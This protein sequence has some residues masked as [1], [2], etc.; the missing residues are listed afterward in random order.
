MIEFSEN[1]ANAMM[2]KNRDIIPS[3]IH[4]P[5]RIRDARGRQP[6]DGKTPSTRFVSTD[7]IGLRMAPALA[8]AIDAWRS[9][10]PKAISRSEAIR[11]LLKF[12]LA[13]APL[14]TT[15]ADDQ[16]F[17]ERRRQ[18]VR[19]LLPYLDGIKPR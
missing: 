14:V 7:L 1:L 8:D 12:S 16:T 13:I 19:A 6:I 9:E 5:R 15:W 4:R 2:N 17:D 18:L 10:Q 11:R 3:A